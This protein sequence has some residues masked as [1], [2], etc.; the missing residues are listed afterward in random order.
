ML[1][2]GGIP[3]GRVSEDE[4]I[5]V[6]R[7]CY[8]LGINFYDTARDYGPSEER[9]GKALEDV[10]GEI[11]L[12]TKSSKRTKEGLLKD[13]DVSLEK[14]RT[15][16]IDVYQLH[17]V[18]SE[19]EWIQVAAPGGALDGLFEAREAGKIRHLGISC[20][21]PDLLVKILS[22]DIF[23][24]V[25]IHH[26]YLTTRPLEEIASLCREKDVGV[27]I[28]KALGGGALRDARTA[29]KYVLAN[30]MVDVVI[31]GMMTIEEV[32][33]NVSVASGE[34]ALSEEDLRIMRRDEEELG[35]E[36]CR[37]C[38]YCQPCLQEI[39]IS[40]VLRVESV[41]LNTDGWAPWVVNKTEASES[42]VASCLKCG[43]CE[44]R[45]P[46]NLPI[47]NLLPEKMESALHR[48]KTELIQ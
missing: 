46:Y 6:V 24:T 22:E 1:G 34:H 8:E 38:D 48:L 7:R 31:P 3:I 2:F 9:I 45:C 17:N 19:E 39:P 29:L 4:A 18:A 16:W 42:K 44:E 32:E 5:E 13:L 14:L 33:E 25:M 30:D 37:A 11:I 27:I 10:R 12:A 28:M 35:S 41:F 23:D 15:H 21:R 20:H 40:F 47:R 26:N 43:S 36:F